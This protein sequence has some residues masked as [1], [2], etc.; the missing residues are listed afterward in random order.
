MRRILNNKIDELDQ[1]HGHKTGYRVGKKVLRVLF[2]LIR[3]GLKLVMF[4][5]AF[6]IMRSHA[7]PPSFSE[8]FIHDEKGFLYDENR[9]PDDIWDL[10][11][12]NDYYD[13]NPPDSH[14]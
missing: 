11:S 3:Y 8:S 13:Q 14:R 7:R 2:L 1:A 6:F 9:E 5:F 12:G 10:S 4:L